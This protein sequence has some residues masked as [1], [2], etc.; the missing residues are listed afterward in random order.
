MFVKRSVKVKTSFK[1]LH[2]WPECPIEEVAFLRDPHRHTFYVSVKMDVF[3]NDRE[4]EFFVLQMAIN[5][6]IKELYG[7][8]QIKDLGRKSCEDIADEIHRALLVQYPRKMVIEVSEDNEVSAIN[9]YSLPT[10][11]RNTEDNG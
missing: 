9:E 11:S 10:Y 4:V 3:H 8:D 7:D 5:D 6:I 1:G 2:C